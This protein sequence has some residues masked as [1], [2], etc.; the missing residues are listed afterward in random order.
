MEELIADTCE[1][2]ENHEVIHIVYH[3]KMA[4]F[5][6]Y[7]L[8]NFFFFFTQTYLPNPEVLVDSIGHGNTLKMNFWVEVIFLFFILT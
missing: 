3:L 7:F 8:I 5:S 4:T 1:L 6:S 2:C